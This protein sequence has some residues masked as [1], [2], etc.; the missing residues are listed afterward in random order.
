M[1]TMLSEIEFDAV[2][3][4]LRNFG[5][6]VVRTA[7]DEGMLMSAARAL[8]LLV[9][10]RS[11]GYLHLRAVDSR[12]WLGRHTESLTDGPTPLQYFALGCL[13]PAAEG[14]ETHLYDGSRAA[15]LLAGLLPGA[16]EVRIRYRSGYRPEVSDH[17]L[18]VEHEQ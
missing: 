7:G 8:G 4:E 16:G 14:G 9:G 1:S 6:A 11:F 15:R 18:V 5:Y 13:V 10:A 12:V 3:Q 17:P 2:A